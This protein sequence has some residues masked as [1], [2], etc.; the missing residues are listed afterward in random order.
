MRASPDLP[1]LPGGHGT[2]KYRFPAA[3]AALAGAWLMAWFSLYFLLARHLRPIVTGAEHEILGIDAQDAELM[4]RQLT[5][6]GID[7]LKHPLFPLLARPY[8]ALIEMVT[9]SGSYTAINLAVAGLAAI[10]VSMVALLAF[11]V[12]RSVGLALAC[13][14][15]F[16][17]SFSALVL[18][19]VPETYSLTVLMLCVYLAIFLY[20]R[21]RLDL[22][23]AL[24]LGG[25]CGIVDLA[26][27]PMLTLG[28]IPALYLFQT[29]AAAR[30]LLL[31]AVMLA[32]S[33]AVYLG[34]ILLVWG[35]R[36][37]DASRQY[38]HDWASLTNFLDPPMIALALVQMLPFSVA[39]PVD[40]ARVLYH[41]ADA[42]GYLS[43][44]AAIPAIA[45]LLAGLAVSMRWL[46]H[47]ASPLDRCLA[48]WAA[49]V[50]LFY[51]WFNPV[52]AI[53]YG[54]QLLPPL[55]LL[56]LRALQPMV[57]RGMMAL[58]LALV[59]ASMA[60]S[61]LPAIFNTV[62]PA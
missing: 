17:L 41:L 36:Y 33:I 55:I 52:E 47:G 30:S 7:A 12:G 10:N 9:G 34:V 23:Q 27:P 18:M 32:T 26:N 39:S 50:I 43:N 4:M 31:S 5:L 14:T 38:A 51:I 44:P 20:V 54:L 37:F 46:V 1:L 28:I 22:P 53:L 6:Q 35:S 16:G 13:G 45:A 61:N 2:P 24:L 42:A 21:D 3:P 49:V 48:T 25:F 29:R 15:V 8:V 59:V 56:A 19:A 62:A 58:L 60:V 40:E 11:Q 57:K